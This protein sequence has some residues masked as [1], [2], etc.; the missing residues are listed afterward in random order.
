MRLFLN[1]FQ[2]YTFFDRFVASLRFRNGSK[3]QQTETGFCEPVKTPVPCGHVFCVPHCG[4]VPWSSGLIPVRG[5]C[6]SC[7]LVVRSVPWRFL[8]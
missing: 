7:G 3:T 1:Y 6:S 4:V 5:C 2:I 8:A